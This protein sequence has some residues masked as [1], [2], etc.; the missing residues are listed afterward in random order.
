MF[1]TILMATDGSPAV[2]RLLVFTESLARRDQAQVIVVHAYHVPAVYEWTAHYEA[3]R[4]SLHTVA[5]EVIDDAV[6][7]LSKN[8]IKA[9]GELHEGDAPQVIL[10]MARVHQADLIVMGSRSQKRESMAEHLL[11][12][13]SLA[14]LRASY[15]PVLL[16]P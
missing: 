6:E 11:G 5:Q 15:C 9:E 4:E 10:D 14:V 8:G 2:E 16:I 7:A 13:V 3:M 12:S 1:K